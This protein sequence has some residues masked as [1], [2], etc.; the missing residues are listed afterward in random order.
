MDYKMKNLS[1]SIRRS[2]YN[3][4]S[5][6]SLNDIPP[7]GEL[8]NYDIGLTVNDKNKTSLTSSN[9]KF[10]TCCLKLNSGACVYSDGIFKDTQ[11]NMNFANREFTIDFWVYCEKS[12]AQFDP[13]TDLTKSNIFTE[14]C[15]NPYLFVYGMKDP[16]F[17]YLKEDKNGYRYIPQVFALGY[18]SVTEKAYVLVFRSKIYQLQSGQTVPENSTKFIVNGGEYYVDGVQ[19][20]YTNEHDPY[21]IYECN[22]SAYQWHHITFSYSKSNGAGIYIDYGN[23]VN[24]KGFSVAWASTFNYPPDEQGPSL[25]FGNYGKSYFRGQDAFF[26]IGNHATPY[27]QDWLEWERSNSALYKNYGVIHI[28][29][30]RVTDSCLSIVPE[31]R[32]A[33]VNNDAYGM[34][35]GNLT[36]LATNWSTLS[37]DQRLSCYQ[38][39]D[40][41]SQFDAD[42][43]KDL[44][45][46]NTYELRIESYTP[47]YTSTKAIMRTDSD[48]RAVVEPKKLWDIGVFGEIEQ[49][50]VDFTTENNGKIMVAPTNDLVNGVYF[51]YDFSL[52][53]W[54]PIAASEIETKGIQ[55]NQLGAIPKISWSTL[56][57][58]LAFGYYIEA[59]EEGVDV[60]ELKSIDAVC[61]IDTIQE[62]ASFVTDVEYSYLAFDKLLVKFL[63][64]GNY[65][66]TYYDKEGI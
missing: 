19:N 12:Y 36:Q 65:K 20:I 32:I 54:K 60:A 45:L 55:A 28:D 1:S 58:N 49:M 30:L 6:W 3:F 7:L 21:Q 16:I 22:M 17:S 34:V 18:N 4:E 59:E 43:L 44:V 31:K 13:A 52:Y 25:S 64:K 50:T 56:G 53:Q 38:I 46:D 24:S 42:D 26:S 29:Q 15:T 66:V 51:G 9:V 33:V 10:G 62:E 41:E 14:K 37:S 2:V 63:N 8:S 47:E 39:V 35:N 48:H 61:T 11:D 5:S 40:T 23:P 27:A 57:K